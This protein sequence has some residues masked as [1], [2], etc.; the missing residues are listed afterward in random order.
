LNTVNL[1]KN[2]F[3]RHR[4]GQG[5]ASDVVNWPGQSGKAYSY[6]VYPINVTLRPSPGNFIYAGQAQDGRWV[7]IYIAQSRNLQQRLEGHVSAVDAMTHGA[8]H[9]HA[10]YDTVGQAARCNEE[11]D[12]VH[13]WKPMCND[14]IES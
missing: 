11:Q 7:P 2:L 5:L 10:H 3:S 6:T 4:K 1:F 12:L 8:T 14:P 13:R 9:L